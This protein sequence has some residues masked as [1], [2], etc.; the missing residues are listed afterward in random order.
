MRTFI[1][2]ELDPPTRRP[3]VQLLRGFPRADGVKW[4]SEPQLHITLKFLGEVPTATL[5][6]VC[7]IAARV[8]RAVPPFEIRLTGL[9]CF[10]APRNPRVLWAGVQD[11]ADGCRR[12]VEL[13]DPEL[14]AIGYKQETR[15]L[16]PHITL[17]RSRSSA[18]SDVLRG[19]LE[20]ATLPAGPTMRVAH[21]TVYESV[22]GPG[23]ARYEV[24]ATASLG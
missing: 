19:V 10:P 21:V 11:A 22:L 9:G 17:G 23:G 6:K 8:S 20:R 1:A 3:L 14:E 12:W 5:P 16:T 24:L 2:I 18:G 13:A 4:C 15:A 7:D